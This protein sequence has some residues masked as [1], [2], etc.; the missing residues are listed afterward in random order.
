MILAEYKEMIQAFS[1]DSPHKPLGIRIK[2]R[3]AEGYPLNL[4]IKRL[5]Q[6]IKSLRE[7]LIAIPDDK[8]FGIVA[9]NKRYALGCF[10][11]SFLI[12][13]LGNPGDIYLPCPYI[14]KEQHMEHLWPQSSPD[15][16]GKKV[17]G[18]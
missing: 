6:I 1:P 17:A 3:G 7:F 12:R 14:N 15:R 10:N 8:F 2:V 4:G 13:V 5:E 9:K 18:P 11:Y 16:L